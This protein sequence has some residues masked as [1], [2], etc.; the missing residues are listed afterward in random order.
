MTVRRLD[1][2]E[3]ALW[4]RVTA[5]VRP[6]E[7]RRL[8][9]AA[10][11]TVPAADAEPSTQPRRAPSP[12]RP[13]PPA[14]A[15][16]AAP[17]PRPG[18]TLDAGWDKKLRQGAVAPDRVIDLHGYTVAAAHDR[19]EQGLDEA[20]ASGARLVLLIAGKPRPVVRGT[21]GPASRG[22]IRAKLLDWLEVSRHAGSI[23]AVRAA[24]QRHGGS[25]A[26]YLVLLRRR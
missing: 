8:R 12:S 26:L 22:A 13:L 4:A 21:T 24:H 19:L 14:A 11:A 20:V 9:I 23:A 2:E 7:P 16:V 5:S 15:K 17:S 18:M 6:I 1:A 3:R 10:P 25:G